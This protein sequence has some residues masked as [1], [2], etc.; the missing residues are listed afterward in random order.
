MALKRRILANV[1]WRK[2][3]S[4]KNNVLNEYLGK[5]G[6][7]YLSGILQKIKTAHKNK[8]PSVVLIE[9]I[10]SDVVAVVEKK[11]YPIVLQRL[12]DLCVQLERYEIC[13]DI[14][15]F[16]KEFNSKKITKRKKSH[17]VQTTNFW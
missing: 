14:V 11:D 8:Y 4:T 1:E 2:Y 9:F 6:D 15:K 7:E 17:K 3:I 12:L 13:A 5:Y 10:K 16:Q